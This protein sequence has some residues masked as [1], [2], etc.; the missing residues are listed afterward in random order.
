MMLL[1][2]KVSLVTG[3]SCGFGEN[4]ARAFAREGSVVVITYLD[5]DMHQKANAEKIAAEIG[6]ELVMGVDVSKRQSVQEMFKKVKAKYGRLDIL[7]NNAGINRTAD[8][9]KQT[10]RDWLDVLNVNLKGPFI[11]SQEALKIMPNAGRIINIGSISGQY[12]GPRTPSYACAK[13]GLMSLTHNVARFVGH[14][15]ITVN[16]VSPAM[17]ESEM[18]E[19][20][21]PQEM[22]KSLMEDVP[23]KRLGKQDEVTEAVVFLAS[24]GGGYISGQ[25]I[26]INGGL[27]TSGF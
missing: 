8:F 17:I 18:L 9:D 6:V 23:L 2:D 16:C 21:M 25:T 13:A 24:A 22:K 3:S 15:D 7:V 26:G 10:E 4:F 1:K 14:R 11:C 19:M 5:G 27:W 20:T 12:G